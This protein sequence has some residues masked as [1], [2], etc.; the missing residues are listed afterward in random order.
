M[1]D[2]D[3]FQNRVDVASLQQE[4]PFQVCLSEPGRDEALFLGSVYVL[5][6]LAAFR[7]CQTRLTNIHRILQSAPGFPLFLV[8]RGLKARE[9]FYLVRGPKGPLFH[10]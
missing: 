2:S 10:R 6:A 7:G 1:L 9:L 8:V 5:H 3:T 4:P